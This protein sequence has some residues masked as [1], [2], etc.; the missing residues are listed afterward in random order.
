MAS[1]TLFEMVS[2]RKRELLG[3]FL[4]NLGLMLVATSLSATVLH[5][6]PGVGSGVVAA[7]GILFLVL[8]NSSHYGY[9]GGMA[10]SRP[11]RVC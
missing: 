10:W 9:S 3:L 2:M 8:C 4:K 1:T 5:Y 11:S 6:A 7:I